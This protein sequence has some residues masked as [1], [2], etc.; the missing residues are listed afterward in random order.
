M[1]TSVSNENEVIKIV[2]YAV[3]IIQL[4]FGVIIILGRII[5]KR[6]TAD[7]EK[8]FDFHNEQ[9]KKCAKCGE[10]IA[11]LEVKVED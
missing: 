10:R 8:L 6:G 1:Q 5:L 4:L 2:V 11:R 9:Q 7:I 3:G